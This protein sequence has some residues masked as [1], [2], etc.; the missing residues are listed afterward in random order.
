MTSKTEYKD[1]YAGDR[2]QSWGTPA[3]IFDPLHEEFGFTMDGAAS[4]QNALLPRAS[5]LEQPLRWYGE[6]VFC[7]PPWSDIAPFLEL[8]ASAELAVLLVPART[9]AK[10]F[11]KALALG[12]KVRFFLGRPKFVGP[13][14]GN[15]PVDC[16]LL[17][18]GEDD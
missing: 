5:T 9:N 14:V 3:N 6:R 17:I 16:L 12:A 1:W 18:F 7:N 10:W 8:A 15:S 11:H 4:E 13:A 2:L